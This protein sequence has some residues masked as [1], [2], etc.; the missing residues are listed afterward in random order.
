MMTRINICSTSRGYSEHSQ[1]AR[2]KQEQR[3][4]PTT[5]LGSRSGSHRV[6]VSVA[7][8]GRSVASEQR[9]RC[10]PAAAPP[11]PM[12]PGAPPGIPL[13]IEPAEYL[14]LREAWL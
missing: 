14:S 10:S 7:D 11:S 1:Q 6:L 13:V 12:R 3:S 8:R 9:V 2:L 4:T 5:A